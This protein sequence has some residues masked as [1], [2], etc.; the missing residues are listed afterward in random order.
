M[1]YFL[2]TELVKLGGIHDGSEQNVRVVEC[3]RDVFLGFS[4]LAGGCRDLF[5]ELGLVVLEVVDRDGLVEVG[6]QQLVPFPLG[7]GQ[8]PLLPSQRVFVVGFHLCYGFGKLV[9]YL[10]DDFLRE[11]V[12]LPQ[13]LNNLLSALRRDVWQV[14]LGASGVSAEAEQVGVLVAALAAGVAESH[15]AVASPTAHRTLE[16]VGVPP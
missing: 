16:V 10:L 9:P 5:V 13:P 14:A 4:Q 12:L 2:G 6:V 11:V 3:P 8:S 15:P 7:L 1:P